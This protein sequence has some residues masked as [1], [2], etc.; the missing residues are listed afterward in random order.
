[1]PKICVPK[2]YFG[3]MRCPSCQKDLER[4]NF[5]KHLGT[6]KHKEKLLSYSP[7]AFE[8]TALISF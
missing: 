4:K 2:K 8:D 1:M 7:A 3:T 6:K 5:L